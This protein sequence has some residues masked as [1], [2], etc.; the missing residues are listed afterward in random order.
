MLLR[1]R[2]V[3]P[4]VDVSQPPDRAQP[5]GPAVDAT[6]VACNVS[7]VIPPVDRQSMVFRLAL[8]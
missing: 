7:S 2:V 4:V 8:L 3:L 1:Q 5:L 6:D